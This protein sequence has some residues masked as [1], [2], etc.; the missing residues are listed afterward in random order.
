MRIRTVMLLILPIFLSTSTVFNLDVYAEP[1][2][3]LSR[4]YVGLGVEVYAPHQCYPSDI[5]TISI[6][7][8]A[9]EDVKNASVNLFIWGSK[10]E[11]QNP[12][13]ISFTVLDATDFPSGMIKE[14]TYNIT[15][16]SDIDPGLAYGILS[17][18]WS[19]YTQSL[20]EDQWDK[21]SFRVT[22]IKN[23]DYEDLQTTHNSVLNEMQNIRTITYVLVATTIALIASTAYLAKKKPKA[24]KVS[25]S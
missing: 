20:W 14:E 16:P 18:Q 24:K 21:A 12:W 6:R 2:K 9:L 11:G 7:V 5:I 17:L 15:I 13:G 22:Y 23:K 19:V 25:S 10:S 1:R 3:V 4:N 8:E